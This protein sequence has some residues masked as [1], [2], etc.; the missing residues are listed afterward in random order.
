MKLAYNTEPISIS[1]KTVEN[2][3]FEGP[4]FLDVGQ[5]HSSVLLCLQLFGINI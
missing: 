5:E 4:M 3:R 2:L 1:R